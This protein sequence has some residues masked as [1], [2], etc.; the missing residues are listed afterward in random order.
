MGNT[1]QK[2]A[3]EK[4]NVEDFIYEFQKELKISLIEDTIFD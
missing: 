4:G 1:T 3:N 2:V